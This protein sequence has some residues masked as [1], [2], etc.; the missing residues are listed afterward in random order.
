MMTG[1]KG[2][3]I[4]ENADKYNRETSQYIVAYLDLLG[5][6][7][8]MKV[9]TDIQKIAMNKLHNLY[10]F[11]MK[12]SKEIA[13]ESYKDIQFKIFSDNIIIVKK[14]SDQP[15]Q[16]LLDIKC[17]LNCVSHFQCSVV[18]DSVG[19]L[20]RGGISI[21]ELYIDE[22]MV[23][24]EAL[25]KAYDLEN[26]VAIYPRILFDPKMVSEIINGKELREY[27]NQDFDNMHYLNCLCI[28]HFGG[29]LL[30]NGFQMMQDELNGKYSE[31]VYQKLYWHMNYV[32]RELDKKNE[33]GEKKYRLSIN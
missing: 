7:T 13:V 30:M 5:V 23:W 18:G 29:Q 24:G 20:V 26:N 17:L 31:H 2:M 19:W 8:R 32:N 14:L 33:R 6:A 10:T 3:M 9:D 28:Q 25:L 27:I 22:T 11:S 21:G 15:A 4:N 1:V 12:L 16:R